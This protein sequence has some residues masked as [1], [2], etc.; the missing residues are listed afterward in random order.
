MIGAA[1]V[2]WGVAIACSNKIDFLSVVTAVVNSRL[3]RGNSGSML[4][5]DFTNRCAARVAA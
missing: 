3:R 1:P 5:V 2:I 4:S